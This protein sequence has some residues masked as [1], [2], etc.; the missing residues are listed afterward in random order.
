ME[1]KKT[2]TTYLALLI[3]GVTFLPA[4]IAVG[5]LGIPGVGVGMSGIGL[6]LLLLGLGLRYRSR[7]S[8]DAK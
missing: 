8:G 3:I 2:D 7:P 6:V 4:G 1:T 5:L